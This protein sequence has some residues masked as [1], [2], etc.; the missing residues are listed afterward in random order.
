MEESEN[1]LRNRKELG[2]NIILADF[3][4]RGDQK[5]RAGQ[6]ALTE[7]DLARPAADSGFW[8]H[9]DQVIAIAERLGL[10][11][12]I[13]PVWGSSIVKSGKL[14]MGNVD[15]YMDFVLSRYHNAPNLIWIV[16]GDVR[17]D[18]APEVFCRMGQRMKADN[19]DRLVGYHPFGRTTSAFWFHQ[20]TWLDF[21]LFQ[22][23]HRRYD[24]K[25]LGAW[26]DNNEREGWFGEDNWRY[27]ER[28]RERIPA[29]PVLDGEPS[30]EG[31][32][33]GLHDSTQPYWQAADVRRYAYWS[34]LAGAAGHTYGHNSVM[35]FYGDLSRKG[36][37]GAKSLWTDAVHHPGGSQMAFLKAL[38]ESVDTAKTTAQL[39]E[40]KGLA[41]LV[42]LEMNSDLVLTPGALEKETDRLLALEEEL[43][44]QGKTV[45]VFTKRTLL[46]VENDS[47]EQ[48]L[49]RSVQISRALRRLVGELQ[50]APVFVVAKG[51]ITSSDVGVKALKVKRATVSGQI[52]PGIPVWQTGP[53]SRF[54]G[55]P[56]II[57]PGNVGERDTLKKVVETL[58]SS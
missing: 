31:I 50:A 27:V 37:Y 21:N 42:F 15:A 7:D 47:P 8:L 28:V 17:G 19:P 58:M 6:A 49:V 3:I 57:F 45:C 13:L 4:H 35:Q 52:Q 48:A 32:P 9:V 33:Q 55:I 43:I 46:K 22:S 25:D 41:Q 24:Q 54:P 11:M 40:L 20:E 29:R 39:E 5:N 1:Y 36:A 30:Y 56:Y 10:Y 18:V 23:G 14:N 51:G 12:G 38:M 44:P 2:F 26:D 16:G 34:V 53:E